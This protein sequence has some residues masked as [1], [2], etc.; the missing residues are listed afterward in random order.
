[1]LSARTEMA[2]GIY[3]RLPHLLDNE[4]LINHIWSD[5]DQ[6]RPTQGVTHKQCNWFV[7]LLN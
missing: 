5:Y 3:C 1:M 6:I 7:Q 2:Q 4:K